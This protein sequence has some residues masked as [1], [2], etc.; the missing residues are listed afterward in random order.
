LNAGVTSTNSPINAAHALP[1]HFEY[2]KASGM[3]RR[4]NVC[5]HSFANVLIVAMGARQIQSP[6]AL[7]EKLSA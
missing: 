6:H 1:I 3:A 4:D 5:L 2:G 7:C